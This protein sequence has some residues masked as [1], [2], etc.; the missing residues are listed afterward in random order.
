MDEK[1]APGLFARLMQLSAPE[2]KDLLEYLGQGPVSAE[3]LLNGV[4][5]RR[6]SARPD[7]DRPTE[8]PAAP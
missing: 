3:S 8:P 4:E 6:N 2:R 5:L 1:I 7:A